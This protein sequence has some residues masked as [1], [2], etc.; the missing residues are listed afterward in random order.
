MMAPPS[1]ADLLENSAQRYP[2]RTAVLVPGSERVTYAE[3]KVLSDRVRDRLRYLGVKPGDRVGLQLRKSAAAVAVLFGILKAG[4]TYVPVDPESPDARAA[5]VL[6]NCRVT[7]VVTERCSQLGLLEHL[8]ELGACPAVFT[9]EDDLTAKSLGESLKS[10]ESAS[11]MRIAIGQDQLAYVLH[12]SGSTGHPK[13]VILSHGNALCFVNWCSETFEPTIEDRISAHAPLHFDLSVFDI[14]VTIK[15]G[16]TMVLIRDTLGKEPMQLAQVISSEAITIW[17]S[18]PSILGLLARYGKMHRYGYSQLR[19][20]LFAGEVLPVSQYLAL[21]AI[22]KGPRFFNLYGAT[23]ANVCAWYE[24][25]GDRVVAQSAPFPLGKIC[26]PNRGRV[27]DAHGERVEAGSVGELVVS[28][29]I[30]MR[31]YWELPERNAEAF[32][33]DRDGIRWYRTGDLVTEDDNVGLRYIGRRD[34]MVK[35]RGFRVE[36]GEIEAT[37]LRNGKIQDVAVVAAPNTEHEVHIIAFVSC[38]PTGSL[39]MATLRSI[40]LRSLPRYMVPDRFVFVDDVPRTSTNK[41]DYEE[42]KRRHLGAIPS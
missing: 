11:P 14:Y 2:D 3:L 4:A 34:R 30:V 27:V 26:S 15:H 9:L 29:P 16:A 32:L 41:V 5:F 38:R 7:L 39:S 24:I 6:N 37:L 25:P 21:R 42:L 23:E 12:T 8:R 10:V 18:T 13:G 17:Y 22:W 1:L 36:L 19:M 28:G 40:S 33:I 31:G 20:V 35:R